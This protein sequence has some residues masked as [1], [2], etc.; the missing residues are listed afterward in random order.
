MLAKRGEYEQA[1]Q[2]LR[3]V[4]AAQIRVLGPTTPARWP[5]GMRSPG[6]SPGGASM[7]RPSGNTGTCSPS[8]CGSLAPTIPTRALPETL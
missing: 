7:S 8:R 3:D 6:C 5:P 4:L 2:E 1:E